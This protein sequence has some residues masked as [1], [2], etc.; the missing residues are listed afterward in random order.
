MHE[1]Q[2]VECGHFWECNDDEE[3]CDEQCPGCGNVNQGYIEPLDTTQVRVDPDGAVRNLDMREHEG[4]TG[5]GRALEDEE[6]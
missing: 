4:R 5:K 1:H 3:D 6:E 2:C